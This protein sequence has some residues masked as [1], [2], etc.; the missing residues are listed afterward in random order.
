MA[1]MHLFD[2]ASP[3]KMQLHIQTERLFLARWNN[4]HRT[5]PGMV[6]SDKLH[7]E[8]GPALHASHSTRARILSAIVLFRT[9]YMGNQHGVLC[10]IGHSVVPLPRRSSR[11]TCRNREST[12]R[13]SSCRCAPPRTGEIS[14]LFSR[15]FDAASTSCKESNPLQG[16]QDKRRPAG[17]KKICPQEQLHLHLVEIDQTS[18]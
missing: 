5:K 1:E 10:G 6:Q 17:P 4:N 7:Q 12:L 2:P 18:W 3:Q 8:A 13:I 11:S 9:D 14:T 15:P 16:S